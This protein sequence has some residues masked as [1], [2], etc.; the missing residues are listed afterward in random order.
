LWGW[1]PDKEGKLM[2]R[3]VRRYPSDLTDAQWE[4]IR[5]LIPRSPP[6]GADR[7]VSIREVVNAV[8]YISR[9]GCS[10]R[11]LPKDFPPWQ[12]VYGYF[13]RWKRDGTWKQ[14]HDTLRAE[15]RTKAGREEE[16]SAG[17]VDSQSVKTTEKGGCMGTMLA[18][19]STAASGISS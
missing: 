15:V 4:K 1:R 14:I 19:K 16:P 10:W 11:M 2:E 6:I 9:G 18:R 7:T 13:A 12:T 5:Q 3:V 17:I 8:F